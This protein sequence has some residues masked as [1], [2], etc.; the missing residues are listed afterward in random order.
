M[1]LSGIVAWI[2]HAMNL[3][4]MFV[5]LEFRCYGALVQRL[6]GHVYTRQYH[7]F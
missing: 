5:D 7:L 4:T 2:P 6:T 1:H 3:M